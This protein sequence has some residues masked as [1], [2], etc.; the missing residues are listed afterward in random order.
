MREL[1][2]RYRELATEHVPHRLARTLLRVVQPDGRR[3]EDGLFGDVP[4]SRRELAQ[5][6]GTTLFTVSRLLSEWERAG[7]VKARR[8]CVVVPDPQALI[9]FVDR[10]LRP[11]AGH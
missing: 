10:R 2:D 3:F 11:T 5:L 6:T 7:V 1:E 4:L 8:E 9:R